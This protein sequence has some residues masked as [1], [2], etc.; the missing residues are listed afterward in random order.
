MMRGKLHITDLSPASGDDYVRNRQNLRAYPVVE[1]HDEPVNVFDYAFSMKKAG[2]LPSRPFDLVLSYGMSFNSWCQEQQMGTSATQLPNG[3][4]IRFSSTI[5]RQYQ[6]LS[7]HGL[8]MQYL[9]TE[10]LVGQDANVTN[11]CIQPANYI[12]TVAAAMSFPF[13]V[14]RV[15][16]DGYL[17]MR[18]GNQRNPPHHPLVA[19]VTGPG[20]M[21]V[22][23]HQRSTGHQEI[24]LDVA[25]VIN[26]TLN[27]NG[28]VLCL[29]SGELRHLPALLSRGDRIVPGAVPITRPNLEVGY[30]AKRVSGS[31]AWN[32]YFDF[33]INNTLGCPESVVGRACLDNIRMWAAS[34]NVMWRAGVQQ[35]MVRW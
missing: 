29:G 5:D 34:R 18:M 9:F 21:Q 33:C 19:S 7:K 17:Q 20:V 4:P 15:E 3:K 12:T 28:E 30:F 32:G 23:T 13:H 10:T 14:W 8:E 22:A 35:S 26:S 25:S 16:N 24:Q 31:F 2:T 11:I 1:M 6:Y 27:N